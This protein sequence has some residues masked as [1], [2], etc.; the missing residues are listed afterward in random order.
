LIYVYRK[1]SIVGAAGWD[2]IFVNGTF[3]AA[4]HNG[5][6]ASREEPQGTVVFSGL[7]RIYIF[8]GDLLI[9]LTDLQKKQFE[10]LR[11]D[12]EK[13][14]TYY[15]KWSVGG[16]MKLM[17]EATGAKEMAKLHHAKIEEEKDE[18]K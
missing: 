14:R 15:V 4:L 6:F 13:G 10:R 16:K 2:R 18:G 5:E 11:M 8:P 3:L 1:S 7:P 17:D 12:A 9:A